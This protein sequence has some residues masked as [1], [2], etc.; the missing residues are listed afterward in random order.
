MCPAKVDA[1]TLTGK[2]IC[3][4]QGWFTCQGDGS[5]LGWTHWAKRRNEPFAPGNVQVDLWPDMS[6]LDADERYQ[7]GFLRKDGSMAE[8]YS[9]GNQKTVMRHFQWMQDYGIDG[10]FLQ[11]FAQGLSGQTTLRH[12]NN[13][14]SHVRNG[15]KALGRTYAIMYDLSGLKCGKVECCIQDDWTMLQE[16]TNLTEDAAY[17]HHKGKPVVAVWGVGFADGRDYTLNECRNLVLWLKEQ[18]CTVMLGVPSFW[19]EGRRDAVSDPDLRK[20]IQAADIVS[21]WSVGRYQSPQAA[22][23]HAAK[24]WQP[25]REWCTKCNL[26]FLPVVFPCF[27][28]HNLKGKKLGSIPRL[29]GRFLWSQIV[30]AKRA[31]CDMI[32]MAMFD[33]VDEGTAIYKTTNEPP[34]GNGGYFLTNDGLSN[35]HYLKLAGLAGMIIRGEAPVV[36]E[37]PNLS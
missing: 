3:G 16:S 26:D 36:D 7:T 20:L 22:T 24:I 13:V 29:K 10:V 32:Y 19:R 15:A 34:T 8:V 1:S 12:K 21:P 17:L 23:Q 33:E 18:G 14:L 37:M 5:K 25:D 27:S 4:Y 35:D 6:E 2:V 31:G 9:N 30:G 11:R 28:W